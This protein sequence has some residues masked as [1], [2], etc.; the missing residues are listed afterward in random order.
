MNAVKP[1]EGGQKHSD[2]P[3]FLSG[4]LLVVF[5]KLTG[6]NSKLSF[7]HFHSCSLVS[8]GHWS[9]QYQENVQYVITLFNIAMT[10]C[11]VIK[12]KKL[13][14]THELHGS[15]VYGEHRSQ[16]LSSPHPLNKEIKLVISSMLLLNKLHMNAMLENLAI[17]TSLTPI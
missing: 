5:M 10:M 15:Y 11:I 13:M 1:G 7:C 9:A 8:V 17:A 6:Q 14:C 4:S 3:V 2:T 16:T 12:K